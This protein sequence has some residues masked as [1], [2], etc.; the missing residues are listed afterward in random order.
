M[1]F[2]TITVQY[3]VEAACFSS[4][5]LGALL[6]ALR[7]RDPTRVQ[8]GLAALGVL[9]FGG[10]VGALAAL[11]GSSAPSFLVQVALGDGLAASMAVVAVVLLA[12]RSRHAT[13]AFVVLNIVGLAG[14]LTSETWLECLEL[15]GRITRHTLVHG[16]TIGAALF[17]AVH[18][19]SFCL[20]AGSAARVQSNV[21]R[22]I[23][24]A[25][26]K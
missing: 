4:I 7:R 25:T 19:L 3:L 5:A 24:L 15:T 16:P 20:V 11:H 8:L 14:I 18:V 26:E 9:R 1:I 22:K 21:L 2:E 17:T 12:R 10:A 6:P 13:S 23:M